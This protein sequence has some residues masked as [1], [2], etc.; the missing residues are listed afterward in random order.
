MLR[1]GLRELQ[2]NKLLVLPT[3]RA[4]HPDVEA[5]TERYDLFRS[6]G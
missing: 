4:Q 2:G 5:L 1:Y 3:R 6:A